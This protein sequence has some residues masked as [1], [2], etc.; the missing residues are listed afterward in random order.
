MPDKDIEDDKGADIRQSKDERVV[1]QPSNGRAANVCHET[2]CGAVNERAEAAE[3]QRHR[4]HS[5]E[6]WQVHKF[7][8]HVEEEGPRENEHNHESLTHRYGGVS[9][10][11]CLTLIFHHLIHTQMSSLD[12]ADLSGRVR[13]LRWI[14]H[15]HLAV[16]DIL[17][18]HRALLRWD[19]RP[20]YP[21]VADLRAFRWRIANHCLRFLREALWDLVIEDRDFRWVLIDGVVHVREVIRRVDNIQ[22]RSDVFVHRLRQ[23]VIRIEITNHDLI[24][25]LLVD[26]RFEHRISV[27]RVVNV[28]IHVVTPVLDILDLLIEEQA[29]HKPVHL[30]PSEDFRGSEHTQRKCIRTKVRISQVQ[31]VFQAVRIFECRVFFQRVPALATYEHKLVHDGRML[32]V[33]CISPGTLNGGRHMIAHVNFAL[34]YTLILH[35]LPILFSHDV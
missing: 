1:L 31:S 25:L 32:V 7:R 23:F 12:Q 22:F 4:R 19:N 8:R 35:L 34:S 5:G 33:S 16:T 13:N 14:P 6:D 2:H 21:E 9:Q 17:S 18:E 29:I 15:L 27:L 26:V 11:P 28:G 24:R 20:Q 30:L 10:R 3:L